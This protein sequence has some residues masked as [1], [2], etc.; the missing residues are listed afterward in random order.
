MSRETAPTKRRLNIKVDS[1]LVE[2]AFAY[3]ER[4]KTTVTQLI[5]DSFVQM[6][7][8]EE[9]LMREDAEQI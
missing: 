1:A 4:N 5:T 8:H 2:W 6:Q 9:L 3:A 7:R